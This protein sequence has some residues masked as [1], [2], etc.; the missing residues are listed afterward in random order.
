M[1]SARQPANSPGPR[2][3]SRRKA[4]CTPRRVDPVPAA[5]SD[6]ETEMRDL[7]IDMKPEPNP[8]L[9]QVPGLGPFSPKEVPAPGRFEGEPSYSP[10]PVPAGSLHAIGSQNQWARWT[11][12]ILN[13]QGERP[14]S[15]APPLSP[16]T[17]GWDPLLRAPSPASTPAVFPLLGPGLLLTFGFPLYFGTPSPHSGP[18]PRSPPASSLQTASPGPTNT[19]IC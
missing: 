1:S 17:L 10:G 4:G 8:W 3:M 12:L 6:D 7:V 13:P 18:T 9:L 5:N 15:R 19:Q 11:P 14:L 2:L 16:F